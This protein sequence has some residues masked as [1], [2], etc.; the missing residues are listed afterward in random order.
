MGTKVLIK[1]LS[2][3]L[4]IV[5][6]ECLEEGK[7]L[8]ITDM[9]MTLEAS[10]DLMSY[11][12]R[13]LTIVDTKS[14]VRAERINNSVARLALPE[15]E[16]PLPIPEVIEDAQNYGKILDPDVVYK[17]PQGMTSSEKDLM[18]S[19]ITLVM[20]MKPSISIDITDI[21][22]DFATR[23]SQH[24]TDGPRLEKLLASTDTYLFISPTEF[25]ETKVASTERT[26]RFLFN[27]EFAN[28]SNILQD[29]KVLPSYFG[30]EKIK[31]DELKEEI[32]AKVLAVAKDRVASYFV[33]KDSKVK[34]L[35]D[36]T[37]GN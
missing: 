10:K 30:Q 31:G 32:F 12:P 15:G 7:A 3:R 22:M 5:V 28:W 2:N 13:G 16:V 34:T 33:Q 14:E 37:K 17:V 8:D 26:Q 29:Y 24:I 35:L 23:I 20:Y 19:L 4:K 21:A 11:I 27:G 36:F 1:C 18:L 25:F 9:R 6:D